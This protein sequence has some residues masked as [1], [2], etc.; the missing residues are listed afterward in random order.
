MESFKFVKPFIYGRVRTR[1]FFFVL[2]NQ[3]KEKEKED[4]LFN[5]FA[6]TSPH[7]VSLGEDIYSG[8]KI[9]C[10][11]NETE[12]ACLENLYW[13]HYLY[14]NTHTVC[15]FRVHV[16]HPY[17]SIDTT[18]AWKKLCFI[19]FFSK[20]YDIFN[21]DKYLIFKGKK[22]FFFLMISQKIFKNLKYLPISNIFI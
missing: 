10:A 9:P 5:G 16:V 1:Q 17:S 22:Y 13:K 8:Y 7:F 15:L 21:I 11:M 20:Y 18:A 2:A 19:L 3:R 4:Y 14:P 12:P 6:T